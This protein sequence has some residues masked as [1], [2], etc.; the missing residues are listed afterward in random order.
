M[1]DKDTRDQAARVLA[2]S[3]APA[4][5]TREGPLEPDLPPDRTRQ[6]RSVNFSRMKRAWTGDDAAALG[7]IQYAA[8]QAIQ[9]VFGRALRVIARLQEIARVP[10]ID[11]TSGEPEKHPNGAVKY[12][13]DEW[14]DP[15]EDWSRL[16]AKTRSDVLFTLA[17]HMYEWESNA[18]RLWSE[19]MYA[20]VLWEQAFSHGFRVLSGEAISGKP[21]ID[22]RTQVGH[23]HSAQDRYFAVF[24]SSI[25]RQADALVR[26]LLRIQRLLE[27]VPEH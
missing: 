5:G 3:E 2:E 21:T 6:F 10:V 23:A 11:I 20:K 1:A 12:V 15:V 18:V 8:D 24:Q 17:T 16:D 7:E 26:N 19:A 4:D 25:S 14:G 27:N 22:D 9:T 13:T